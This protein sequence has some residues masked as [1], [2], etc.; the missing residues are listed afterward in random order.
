M[1]RIPAF[2]LIAFAVSLLV[3]DVARAKPAVTGLRLGVHTD[4]TRVVLDLTGSL[5][6]TVFTLPDPYRV[7][8]DLPEVEW[9]MPAKTIPAGRGVVQR[10]RYGLF[11][12]GTSRLVLDVAA[13]VAVRKMFIL[14]PTA[15]FGY[16]LVL[17]LAAVTAEEFRRQGRPSPAVQTQTAR[18]P[19]PPQP[20]PERRG[21]QVIVVDAGHGGVDPGTVGASGTYEKTITLAAARELKRQLEATGRYAVVMTRTRDVFVRLRQRVEVAR[22]AKADLFVSLHADAIANKRVRGATVYTL[23]EKS[24]DTEAAELA[25]KE[26]KSDIIAGIDLASEAYGDD[27]TNILID[28]AQRETMN[29]SAEFANLLIPE[30]GKEG[31]LLRKTHRFAGFRVLK[32]PDVPSVL[33]EMG[34]VSNRKDERMLRDPA[35][36]RDLMRAVVRAID[37]YFARRRSAGR[38]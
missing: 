9:R 7:V 27:V 14:R 1:R 29:F 13:P 36:R 37:R 22:N 26:N 25:A 30:L 23:S 21:R 17:D 18:L 33:V 31:R 4:V 3:P 12:P 19:P 32:A 11:Q 10:L 6:Y 35:R 20:V 38:T 34:Y 28:L 16:R 5:D 2:L 8:I 24:S 15:D